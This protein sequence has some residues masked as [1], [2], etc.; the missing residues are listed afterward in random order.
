MD[1]KQKKANQNKWVTIPNLLSLFR[2]LLIPVIAWLYC[3]KKNY[4]FASILVILSGITDIAD[5]YIARKFNMVSDIGKALDPIADKLTQATV[6]ICLGL[7]YRPLWLLVLTMAIKE[8]VSGLMTLM[9]IQKT[10]EIIGADWHGKATTC[11]LYFTMLLHL[12]WVNIPHSL[13]VIL[14][15][16]CLSFMLLSFILYFLRNVRLLRKKQTDKRNRR[17]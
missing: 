16:L 17:R 11:L 8:A 7:R 1:K 5:G 9:A 10:K 15:C 13:T 2:L 12:L 14:T 4:I 3:G 6:L